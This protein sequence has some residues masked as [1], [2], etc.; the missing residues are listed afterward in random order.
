MTHFCPR[1]KNEL[2]RTRRRGLDNLISKVLPV[3]RYQC[4]Y[5]TCRWTG[6][7]RASKEE[8][9]LSRKAYEPSL[10]NTESRKDPVKH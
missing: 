3:R 8:R 9:A 6:L 2:I 5:H 1:C 4:T 10:T 7:Q